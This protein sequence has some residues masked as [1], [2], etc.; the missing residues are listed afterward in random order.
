[1]GYRKLQSDWKC[2]IT[3]LCC[4]V[5]SIYGNDQANQEFTF[6]KHEAW[7]QFWGIFSAYITEHFDFSSD[8]K[9]INSNNIILLMWEKIFSIRRGY[10]SCATFCEDLYIRPL[11]IICTSSSLY[12]KWNVYFICFLVTKQSCCRTCR[13]GLESLL[14]WCLS[15]NLLT[16]TCLWHCFFC[17][18]TYW[19]Y[20]LTAF[21]DC[22]PF[23]YQMFLGLTTE[24]CCVLPGLDWD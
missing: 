9:L 4:S 14:K 16:W 10:I 1:M 20:L 15:S 13:I 23:V 24:D 21:H 11:N 12:F 19:R 17:Y 7:L 8:L 6:D 18:G 22:L 3:H 2:F 5:W